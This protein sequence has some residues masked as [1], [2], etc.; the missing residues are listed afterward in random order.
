MSG[1]EWAAL[2]TAIGVSVGAV[3]TAIAALVNAR[4]SAALVEHLRAEMTDQ[5]SQIEILK[6]NNL[7]QNALVMDREVAIG[8]LQKS[9]LDLE[10]RL[11]EKDS[12]IGRLN[13]KIRLWQEWGFN[14]GRIMN[15]MQ[16]ELGFLTR[17]KSQTGPLPPLPSDLESVEAG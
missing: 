13:E 9:N 6:A 11:S 3:I 7:A 2:I 15:E 14:V 4:N 10:K 1:G 12:E 17:N 8:K 5:T 16:L